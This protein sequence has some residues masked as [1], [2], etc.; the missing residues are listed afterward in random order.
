M[1]GI[2]TDREEMS[3]IITGNIN[4]YLTIPLMGWDGLHQ[5][6]KFVC[7]DEVKIPKECIAE[8]FFDNSNEFEGLDE[9]NLFNNKRI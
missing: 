5:L 6:I 4:E 3:K 7:R 9:G 8:A 1:T 2:M